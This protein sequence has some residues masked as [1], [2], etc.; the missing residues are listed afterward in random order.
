MTDRRAVVIGAGISG[1]VAALELEKRGFDVHVLEASPFIGGCIRT[2]KSS[3]YMFE[4]GPNSF[5][6]SSK[7]IVD[8]ADELGVK[9]E[10]IEADPASERRFI[11]HR[12][13]LVIVP[14]GPGALIKTRLFTT[15][16]KLRLIGERFIG[17]K[18][19]DAPE[20][21]AEFFT[22]RFGLAPTVTLV[23]AFCSGIYAGDCRRLDL[24]STFP[25]IKELE[26]KYGGV[27]KGFAARAKERRA[28]GEARPKMTLCSFKDGMES[29]AEAAQ[30][31]LARKVWTRSR[32]VKLTRDEKTGE[33]VVA[34]ANESGGAEIRAARV[35]VAAP[36]GIARNLLMP[37]GAYVEDLMCEIEYAPLLVIHAGFPNEEIKKL[38]AGFGYLVPR[39]QRM[40]T[41][42]WLF[43]SRIFPNRA[44]DGHTALS[45]YIGGA[46]DPHILDATQDAVR[47]IVMGELSIALKMRQ[48]PKPDY[49]SIIEQRPGIPQF[50]VGHKKRM[51][52][53]RGLLAP[54]AGMKLIGNYTSGVS[55][56][57]C[58]ATAK[59]L[60]AEWDE[61]KVK[62]GAA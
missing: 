52:A 20:T 46:T 42:G 44:P 27:M 23:D 59:R 28:R 62:G 53:I 40:R 10:I 54:Y 15:M 14:T 33:F 17:P 19:P 32:A 31:R 61:A 1:L 8:F 4:A 30:R 56:G 16:Q 6:S 35:V 2:I 37:L 58:I 24:E 49:F 12:G 55:V 60:V 21:V 57:D 7:D 18:N 39:P 5:P 41:L 51:E 47:N 43:S 36:A 3:G 25:M 45:G 48:F 26:R 11:Y 9:G 13:K 50:T 22:R 38:P 29:L 34:T